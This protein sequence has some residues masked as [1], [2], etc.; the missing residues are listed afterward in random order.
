MSSDPPPSS[1]PDKPASADPQ[2]FIEYSRALHEYT[3]ERW[4]QA[5]RSREERRR[6]MYL[7]PFRLY[8]P[9]ASQSLQQQQQQQQQQTAQQQPV[10]TSSSVDTEAARE[11]HQKTP[12]PKN[13]DKTP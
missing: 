12:S 9:L 1:Q 13:Q 6:L 8:D 4:L 5:V 10:Q 11:E 2:A 7:E 3:L